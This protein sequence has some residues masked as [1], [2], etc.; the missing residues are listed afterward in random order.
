MNEFTP[1]ISRITEKFPDL[2]ITLRECVRE[3]WEA[4]GYDVIIN[5]ENSRIRLT[6]DTLEDLKYTCERDI[7]TFKLLPPEQRPK[8]DP[9]NE[10]Y[11]I[12]NEEITNYL[13][14]KRFH[15]KGI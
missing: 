5:D 6:T 9:F 10:F 4:P 1:I 12:I 8:F 2:N 11:N 15:G 13:D 14:R 3:P 7:T